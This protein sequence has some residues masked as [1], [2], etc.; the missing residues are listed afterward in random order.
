MD[1]LLAGGWEPR[2][3]LGD[4]SAGEQQWVDQCHADR[5]LLKRLRAS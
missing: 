4:A 1:H 3:H 2:P 5:V